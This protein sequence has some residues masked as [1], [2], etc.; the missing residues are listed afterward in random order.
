MI[1]K[2]FILDSSSDTDQDL[3][4]MNL[5]TSYSSKSSEEENYVS[6]V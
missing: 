1:F 3:Q 2:Y 5:D 6:Y 4:P